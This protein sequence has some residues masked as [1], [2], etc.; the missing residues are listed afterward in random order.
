MIMRHPFGWIPLLLLLILPMPTQ[1]QEVEPLPYDPEG[2]WTGAYVRDGAVQQ[3]T[4]TVEVVDDTARITIRNMEWANENPRRSAMTATDDGR[5]AFEAHYGTARVD[6]DEPFR[7][8]V[9]TVGTSTPAVTLHL[10]QAPPPPTHPQP[11]TIDTTFQ[12]GDVTLGATIVLP[13]GDGPFTGVVSVDGRGCNTREGGV[14]RLAWLARRGIGGI[15]YDDRGRG[16][17]EGSCKTSNIETES[18]DARAALQVLARHPAFDRSRIGFRGSS[19]G[20]WVI[21]HAAPRSRVSP[22]F[23]V[24]EAGPAT[25]VEQQQYD[26]TATIAAD[27][28]MSPADSTDFMRYAELTFATDR[29]NE[30]LYAEMQELLD[31]G[32]G[33]WSDRYLSTNPA[34]GDVPATPEGIDSLWVRRYSYDPGPDL[35]RLDVPILAFFGENDYI[36]PPADNVP[37]F[38][39]LT[40]GHDAARAVVLPEAG[41]G[42]QHGSRLRT[43][44]TPRGREDTYYFKFY[45]NSPDYMRL[46][47]DFLP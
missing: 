18:R 34:I 29:P 14:A 35:Q 26:A 4:A 43:I 11:T 13:A 44:S 17:S 42:L 10:K 23:L 8:M 37:V 32:E 36:V 25:S 46:L 7:E 38:R 30:A 45:R 1:A 47:L 6:V 19:A 27:Q 2:L 24:L 9:G 3:V 41:H 39:E 16:A 33:V 12:S 28:G 20:G 21:A 31:R 15:S 5:I 40:R 22:A